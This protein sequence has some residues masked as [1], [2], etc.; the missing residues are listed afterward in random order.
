MKNNNGFSLIEVMVTLVLT[1]I[2]ILG[3][4]AMQGRSIQYTNDSVQRNTAIMLAD[5]LLEIIRANPKAI[6]GPDNNP[7]ETSAYYKTPGKNFPGVAEGEGEEA[8]E[9]PACTPL[10][11]NSA[12][13]DQLHCWLEQLQASLPVDE[14]ILMNEI[15][16]CPS[17][18]PGSCTAGSAIEIQLAWRV[19]SGECMDSNGDDESDLTICHYRVRAEI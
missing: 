3:M 9:G 16:I 13:A 17:Q 14:T 12:P 8:G 4:V 19:K 7:R 11:A 1:T 18:A 10:P 5:D 15:H 2:G 6:K